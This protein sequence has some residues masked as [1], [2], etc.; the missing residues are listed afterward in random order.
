MSHNIDLY[1][2]FQ[3]RNLGKFT[4][5]LEVHEADPNYFVESKGRT[6]FEIISSTPG[7]SSYIKKC[8]EYGADFYVVCMI[9]R[10]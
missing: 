6:V 5:A 1:N 2:A 9:C 7:S 3:N 10:L 4:E 8:I